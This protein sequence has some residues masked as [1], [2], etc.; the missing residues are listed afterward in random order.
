MNVI[1]KVVL[2]Q[3]AVEYRKEFYLLCKVIPS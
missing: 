1:K 3:F 2:F